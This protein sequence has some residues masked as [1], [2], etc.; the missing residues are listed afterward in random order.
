MVQFF[1]AHRL[2]FLVRL[3]CFAVDKLFYGFHR[4]FR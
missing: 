2:F 4:L 3:Y 1:A